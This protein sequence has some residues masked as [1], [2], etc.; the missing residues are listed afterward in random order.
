MDAVDV[1][2][3]AILAA[4]LLLAAVFVVAAVTKLT[5]RQGTRQ[6]I[7]AFGA[8]EALAGPLAL[9]LPVAEL[10]VAGLLLPSETAFAGAIGALAL[11]LLFSAAIAF[12]LARGRAPDCHCFGQLHSEPAGPRTLARNAALAVVAAVAVA[13]TLGGR[14]TS[15]VGWVGGLTATELAIAGSALVLLALGAMAFVSLLKAYGRLLVRLERV[16]ETLA[17]AGLQVPEASL[18]PEFGL[19]LGTPAPMFAVADSA[20]EQVTLDDLLAPGPPLLLLFASPGCG[21]CQALLPKLAGW[22]AELAGRLTLA[23]ASD[24]TPDDLRA[25][26]EELGLDNVLVDPGAQLYRDFEASGTPSA[27]LIAPDGAIASRVALGPDAIEAM[28]AEVRDAPGVAIGAPVPP[29]ALP[30]LDG[31]RVS[32]ADLRGHDTL[33]LFWDPECGY[34]RAMHDDLLAW[35]RASNGTTPRL[36]VVSTGSAEATRSDGFRS[37]VLLDEDFAAG[38]EF[39]VS[40]TPMAVRLDADGRV[41]SGVAAGAD[42]VLDL[43]APESSGVGGPP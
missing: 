4:R 24:G 20:G 30:S 9:A 14:D 13:G 34:C 10:V 8:S 6:A 16:E 12:N 5:D 11:L 26:A 27:V 23:V 22:Q 3:A 41:A 31:E 19:E 21:P 40:G 35:E 38:A 2:D 36:V 15:A 18:G 17:D 1:L 42:A 25:E 43:A 37:K 7:V 28:V 33:L 32:L 39:G 29:L